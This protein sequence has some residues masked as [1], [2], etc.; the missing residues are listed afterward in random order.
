M[1]VCF[2]ANTMQVNAQ[3]S[4]QSAGGD[5]TVAIIAYFDVGDTMIYNMYINEWK[6]GEQDTVMSSGLSQRVMVTV[7]DST[8]K[9]YTMEYQFLDFGF[10]STVTS[11]LGQYENRLVHTLSDK[12]TGTKIVFRTDI[13]GHIVKY[14]N[15]KSI[16]KQAKVLYKESCKELMNM[17]YMD[18]LKS[19]GFNLDA[20][21]KAVDTDQLVQGYVEELE[22]LMLCHGK[23]YAMGEYTEHEDETE[24]QYASDSYTYV[25]DDEENNEYKLVF[26]VN[27]YI[28]PEDTRTLVNNAMELVLDDKELKTEASGEIK[29]VITDTM[30][31]NTYLSMKYFYDGYSE[32]VSQ[33]TTTLQGQGKMKQTWIVWDYR[34]VHH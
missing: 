25:T 18:S 3:E 21:L 30:T 22:L 27:S 2:F 16:K 6:Y 32:V 7:T 11:V 33:S 15:L 17:P 23:Q 31:M 20:M 12:I 10:D 9:G 13:F 8:K 1:T 28:P 5:S 24:E 4:G 14:D 29:E 19:V 34:S 26:D